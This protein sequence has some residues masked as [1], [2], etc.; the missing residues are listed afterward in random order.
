[1]FRHR[2][3]NSRVGR[4]GPRIAPSGRAAPAPSASPGSGPGPDVTL[5]VRRS[6]KEISA[7]RGT[8]RG[9]SPSTDSWLSPRGH[10]CGSAQS[11]AGRIRIA[12][13]RGATVRVMLLARCNR[14]LFSIRGRARTRRQRSSGASTSWKCNTSRRRDVR[15][16]TSTAP[17]PRGIGR[18]DI[19]EDSTQP[20]CALVKKTTLPHE[21]A[22]AAN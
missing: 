10:A 3:S 21:K 15:V 13:A 4:P 5:D 20:A 18:V 7:A 17:T 22:R 2:R 9:L 16:A 1:M 6:K 12:F 11:A 19:A 8:A 14:C